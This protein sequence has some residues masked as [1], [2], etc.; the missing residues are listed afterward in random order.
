MRNIVNRL[1]TVHLNAEDPVLRAE[2]ERWMAVAAKWDEPE[3][4]QRLLGS[5]RSTD[6]PDAF[7]T[8]IDTAQDQ[9]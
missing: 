5:A 3:I 9:T 6:R 4:E 7:A 1:Y 2:I 8:E